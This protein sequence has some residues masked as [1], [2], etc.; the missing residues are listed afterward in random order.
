MRRH[1]TASIMFLCLALVAVLPNPVMAQKNSRPSET[2]TVK[3]SDGESITLTEDMLRQLPAVTEEQ[4]IWVGKSSGYIGI[5]D[6]SG[7]R[8][9]DILK[10]AQ[11]TA[12]AKEYR[13]E[14][15]YLIFRGTDGYQVLASWTEV[16]ESPDGR[17]ALIALDKDGEAL[18]P[19]EGRFRIVF[20][21]DKYVGRSV[22]WLESIEIHCAPGFTEFGGKELN[23]GE[24]NTEEKEASNPLDDEWAF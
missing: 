1:G 3:D 11:T 12:T 9:S 2:L 16:M 4:C 7:P 13:Q 10:F 22:K 5:Y 8:L 17:R 18:D 15:S 23:E 14:N 6:Y 20:P 19:S 21:A 24:V